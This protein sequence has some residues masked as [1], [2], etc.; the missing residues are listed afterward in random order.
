MKVLI[1]SDWEDTGGVGIA[2]KQA[3]DRYSD[4]EARFVR[5]H[6]NYIRYPSDITWD[7]D[8]PKPSGL[9][10]L[11]READVVHVMERWSAVTP[12]DGWRDKPLV[13][14]HHGTEFRHNNTASLLATTKEYGAVGI[15]S[16]LD[17]TLID[18]SVEWLPNPC[19]P[20]KMRQIRRDRSRTGEL[21]LAHSPTNRSIK[22]TD[23]FV[24]Q[25]EGLPVSVDTIEWQSWAECLT[26]K[27]Q[28]DMFFDQ[29]H[30]G[31][32]LSGIEAMAMGIPV[33]SGAYDKKILDLMM[34]VFGYLPF[35]LATEDNLRSRVERF[36]ENPDLRRS[37]AKLGEYHVDTWHYEKTVAKQLVGIYERAM[38]R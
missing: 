2:L 24:N 21:R 9:D 29:L 18:P 36:I 30:I 4:W 37:F 5:R 20:A 38:A 12:F 31:Y 19:D 16:T 22:S 17:L 10:D 25:T 35:Y 32:A 11:F 15:V 34:A 28:A 33:I 3:L 1:L 26:R 14:H 23:L 8:K 27:A 6:D 7:L 13:M